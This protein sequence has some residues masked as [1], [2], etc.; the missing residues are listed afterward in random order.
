LTFSFVGDKVLHCHQ[1][2]REES[3]IGTSSAMV[4]LSAVSSAH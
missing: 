1:K 4:W 3:K 2:W